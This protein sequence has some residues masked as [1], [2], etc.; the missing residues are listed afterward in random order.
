MT[1]GVPWSIKGVEPK[2]RE[3]AK[4]AARKE[5][6]TLG[7]WLNAMILETPPSPE[8]VRQ[9]STASFSTR[10]AEAVEQKLERLS[11]QLAELT[12]QQQQTTAGR[13]I[14]Y[15]SSLSTT[16]SN[17][18][19][20]MARVE[21]H[22]RQTVEALAAINERLSGI[23][24]QFGDFRT[25][26]QSVQV[27]TSLEASLRTIM[28]RIEAGERR[29]RDLL[30]PHDRS[31]AWGMGSV[32]PRPD[33]PD[34]AI[35][36]LESRFNALAQRLATTERN[37]EAAARN[38]AVTAIREAQ[39]EFKT[40]EQ[41]IIALVGELAQA[42]DA[43]ATRLED[44]YRQVSLLAERL[45]AVEKSGL[46]DY[47]PGRI[48]DI[49]KR[50][51]GFD[52]RL[53]AAVESNPSADMLLELQSHVVALT[54][55]L[56]L[57]EER[58]SGIEAIEQSISEL[59]AAMEESS[60][61]ELGASSE[62]QS[63]RNGQSAIERQLEQAD[64]QTKE[65][66]RAVNET[67][68]KVIGRLSSLE[69][70]HNQ[71]QEPPAGDEENLAADQE[72]AAPEP[73][74]KGDMP[75]APPPA[76]RRESPDPE[77][78]PGSS[79]NEASSIDTVTRRDD[80]IAAARRAAQVAA[81]APQPAAARF[82]PL[83]KLRSLARAKSPEAEDDHSAS[84]AAS[85]RKPLILAG[86]ILLLLAAS[87]YT[88]ADGTRRAGTANPELSA[89]DTLSQTPGRTDRAP[90]RATVATK[91][92]A[93]PAPTRVTPSFRDP[94]TT[95]SIGVQRPTLLPPPLPTPDPSSAQRG[96]SDPAARE[97][98]SREDLPERAGSQSLRGAALTGDRLAQFIV[99]VRLIE[100]DGP[101][102]A[103]LAARWFQKAAAQGFAP[104]QYRL[105]MLYER[106]AGVP[107]DIAAARVWYQ[108]AAEKGN[109]KA[110]HNLAVTLA[111]GA[112]APDYAKAA[113][114]F[115][116]AAAYG[117]RD[118]QYNFGVLLE[119]GLGIPEDLAEAYLW[120]ALCARGGDKDAAARAEDL[121]SRLT[122]EALVAM[123]RRVST[124]KP[125]A[126]L[127]EANNVVLPAEWRDAPA[128]RT[129]Q[130]AEITRKMPLA[131]LQ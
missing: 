48:V 37:A 42:D 46:R 4:L 88:I 84:D 108:R 35:S 27:P 102:E 34:N 119:K 33:I 71:D 31:A 2:A 25:S 113:I 121:K 97:S 53:R 114:W 58:F 78:R 69:Q 54:E 91:G 100:G 122:S 76:D 86:A 38:A 89:E 67:L 65:T 20:L 85:S 62:L 60:P 126:P 93:V 6:L 21:R 11:E 131:T 39:A 81:Q 92:Q 1:A 26:A 5:G 96:I 83:S 116:A 17:T 72:P 68:E 106:G 64:H 23:A 50:L 9:A 61:S 13:F 115:A 51:D 112:D 117:I 120:Y 80:F 52:N 56:A 55:K 16:E 101:S 107:K 70:A 104:A 95:G 28:E 118:S 75:P 73:L 59:L 36:E 10:P 63:L 18:E 66:L 128:R 29:Q 14:D 44:L 109:V 8:T 87:A 41:R 15:R 47:D 82:N 127:L 77:L 103:A 124:W 7:E 43:S 3:A 79:R 30:Q 110:M 57:T 98:A 12:R 22:E 130:R 24:K 105:G 90:A 111:G 123:N 125:K 19:V 99:A 94:V 129:D 32:N 45:V 40:A 49:E 74:G